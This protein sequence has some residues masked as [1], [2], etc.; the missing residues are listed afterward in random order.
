MCLCLVISHNVDGIQDTLKK[1]LEFER[2]PKLRDRSPFKTINSEFQEIIDCIDI[3]KQPAFD[4]PLLKNHKLQMQPNFENLIEKTSVNSSQI[5]SMF[6]IHRKKC[7]KGTVPIK[8][9]QKMISLK[10]E[11]LV[12]NNILVKDI[13]GVHIAETTVI[14]DDVVGPYYKVSAINSVYN[15][16]MTEKNQLSSSHVWVE[17]GPIES[18]N[19]I[20]AGW[21]VYPELYGDTKTHFYAAWTKDNFK[22][23]GCHNLQCPGFVQTDRQYSLGFSFPKTSTYGGPII[24][25]LISIAQDPKTKNWWINAGEINIGYYPAALFSNLGSAA[26]VGWGGR[27]QGKANGPSPPMGSG[28]FPDGK[29]IHSGYFRSPKIIDNSGEEF[30]PNPIITKTSTD[31]SDCYHIEYYG[32]QVGFPGVIQYGGPGGANCG[33]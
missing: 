1:D 30:T 31:N 7:P 24:E 2:H 28:Y 8:R 23:T 21:H 19:K 29:G 32:P 17:N 5:E 13:P 11:Y 20:S 18:V 12:N 3:Y 9:E 4:H 27:T 22:K 25:G 6:G 33:D 26:M 16:K 14:Y 10:K 15:P